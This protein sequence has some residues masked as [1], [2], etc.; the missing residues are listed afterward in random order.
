[1][2]LKEEFLTSNRKQHFLYAIPIGLIF[3]ILCVLGVAAGMEFKDKE[4][5]DNW[6]WIDFKWT[7]F[8]G[9]IGQIIQ[10]III[11]SLF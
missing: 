5:T 1:M 6:D 10:A 2:S 3:T 9:I 11:F 7:M 8:G 4:Y